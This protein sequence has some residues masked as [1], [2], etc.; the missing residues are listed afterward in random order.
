MSGSDTEKFQRP[1]I[2]RRVDIAPELWM[3]RV[4]PDGDFKF[5]PGQ[6]AT[7]GLEGPDKHRERPYSTVSAPHES[8]L[9]ILFRTRSSRRSYSAAVPTPTRR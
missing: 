4:Q 5:A 9:E 3:I 7:L 8:E 2:T 6:H 1:K